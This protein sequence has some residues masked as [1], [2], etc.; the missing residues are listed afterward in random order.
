M[1]I[2][3]RGDSW[4][5]RVE[6]PRGEGGRRRQAAKSFRTR[7]EAEAWEARTKAQALDGWVPPESLT[8]EQYLGRYMEA[9]DGTVLLTT[10]KSRRDCLERWKP[11]IGRIPLAKLTRMDVQRA[12]EN[13]APQLAASTRRESLV[14]LRSA[15][16]QAVAWDMLRRDPTLGIRAPRVP[17]EE[18]RAWTAEEA[19]RFLEAAGKHRLHALFVLALSTGMRV[20]EMLALRW[21]DVTGDRIHVR[22]SL[23]RVKGDPWIH[24]PKTAAGTRTVPVGNAVTAALR[25]HRAR[26]LRERLAAG[27][28]WEDNGLVF[29]ARRG[30]PLASVIPGRALRK[31]AAEAGV[32][33]IRMHDL[34][35]THAT[36]LLRAGVSPKVVAERL[37]HTSVKITLDVYS[38]VLPD[39]QEA[40]VRALDGLLAPRL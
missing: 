27:Q 31:I 19:R 5:V 16:R 34:R 33:P 8:V 30:K 18:M 6:L 35:H 9:T 14:A 13:L 12:L 23:G 1:P 24:E 38:H 3:K 21:E 29:C 40:A 4:F 37:G 7:R 36:L 2:T 17:R 10:A 39:M 25:E 26:Q 15:M 20:G 32:R 22:R 28:T 11:L